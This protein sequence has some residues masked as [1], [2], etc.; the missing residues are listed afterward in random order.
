MS[1][2]LSVDQRTIGSLFQDKKSDFIIPDYQRPYA[3]TETQC[4]T[5]WDDLFE[6]AF[7]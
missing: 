4:Q 6:F 2:K 5:L 1:N 7:P 3:W